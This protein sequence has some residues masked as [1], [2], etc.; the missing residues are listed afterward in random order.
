MKLINNAW[1]DFKCALTSPEGII[2]TALVVLLI[3]LT[4]T[5]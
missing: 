5:H 1:A 4:T 3:A 2:W